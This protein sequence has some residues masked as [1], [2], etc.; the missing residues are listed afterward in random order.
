MRSPLSRSFPQAWSPTPIPRTPET[1]SPWGYE[2]LLA[3]CRDYSSFRVPTQ[4]PHYSPFSL[5]TLAIPILQEV[6]SRIG[7]WVLMMPKRVHLEPHL[8]GF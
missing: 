6:G 3:G 4:I 2:P 5:P 7:V 1:T 8:C